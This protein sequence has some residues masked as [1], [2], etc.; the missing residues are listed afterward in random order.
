MPIS[1]PLTCLTVEP[2]NGRSSEWTLHTWMAHLATPIAVNDDEAGW[3]VIYD[4]SQAGIL[5]QFLVDYTSPTLSYAANCG[6]H[7]CHV[8]GQQQQ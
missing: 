2:Q 6:I 3:W 4:L 5:R 8:G 7:K 1:W